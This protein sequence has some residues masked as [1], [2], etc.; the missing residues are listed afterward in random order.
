[1]NINTKKFVLNLARVKDQT[2]FEDAI[3]KLLKD[4]RDNMSDD[5]YE[6]YRDNICEVIDY[7]KEVFWI[8][9]RLS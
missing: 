6:D 4:N 2:W 8:K 1:M 5:I 9:K 7:F 3:E